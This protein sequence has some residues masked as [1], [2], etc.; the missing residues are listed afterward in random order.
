MEDYKNKKDLLQNELLIKRTIKDHL[1]IEDEEKA[2]GLEKLFIYN[3]L[4]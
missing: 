2:K 4:N 1:G 3:L